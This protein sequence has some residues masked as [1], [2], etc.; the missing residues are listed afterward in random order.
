M[1]QQINILTYNIHKGYC[2]GNRRFMLESMRK[3]IAEMSAIEGHPFAYRDR[4]GL[5]IDSDS[6]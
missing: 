1:S 6:N 3:R 5:V 2:T 4:R